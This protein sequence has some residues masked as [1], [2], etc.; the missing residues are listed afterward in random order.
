MMASA[1]AR[2]VAMKLPAVRATYL[3]PSGSCAV[4]SVP[5]LPSLANKMGEAI[6]PAT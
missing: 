6:I 5:A 3:D 1:E 2:R 4:N